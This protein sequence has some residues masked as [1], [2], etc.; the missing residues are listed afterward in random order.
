[1]YMKKLKG[2]TWAHSRGFR[3]IVAV[4]VRYAELDQD[5]FF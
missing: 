5:F 1:M 3:C 2:I 4:S